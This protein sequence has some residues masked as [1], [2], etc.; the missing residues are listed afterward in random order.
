MANTYDPYAPGADTSTAGLFKNFNNQYLGLS[1]EKS[2][3]LYLAVGKS[4]A[5]T[6][7]AFGTQAQKLGLVNLYKLLLQQGKVDPRLLAKAQAQN[8][9]STQQ[10]QDAARAGAAR[11][12][13][14]Q[15]G[16][17]AALQAAIGSAGANRSTNLNYQDISDSYTRNQENL[18]LLNQLVIQPQLG[19]ASLG[20][21]YR[22]TQQDKKNKQLAA[23][24]S[25][26]TGSLGGGLSGGGK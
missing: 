12:G 4:G 2:G 13:M 8:S 18:G 16:L 21:Q 11:S 23:G 14:G 26:I 17:Q 15:G 9:A 19:Y 3:P 24:V 10:Q 1:A 7:G 5:L 22:A 6:T 20:E 25:L